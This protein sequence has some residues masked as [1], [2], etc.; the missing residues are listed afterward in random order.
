MVKQ[1]NPKWLMVSLIGSGVIILLVLFFL[2]FFTTE[3]K[4][5]Q[6]AKAAALDAFQNKEVPYTKEL[7]EISL[8]LPE[9][10]EIISNSENNLILR[11]DEQN[12]ILFYNPF[13]TLDSETFYKVAKEAKDIKLI[14]SFSKGDRFGYIRVIPLDDDTYELQVGVGGVK[15]TTETSK[16]DLKKDARDMMKIVQSIAFSTS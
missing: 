4:A 1:F 8:Y 5:I 6:K 14:D 2:G 3:E 7:E 10:M 16:R 15:M 13:E 11:E 9:S 12:F